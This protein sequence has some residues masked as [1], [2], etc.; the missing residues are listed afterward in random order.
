MR[1][2]TFRIRTVV[3]AAAMLA[4]VALASFGAYAADAAAVYWS[5]ARS[6]PVYSVE[7]TDSKIAIS[8]DCAWG[9]EYTAQILSALDAANVRATFFTVQFWRKNIP[10]T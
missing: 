6:L 3:F 4:A 10:S 5:A 2:F 1:F 7:R 9:D 8:F